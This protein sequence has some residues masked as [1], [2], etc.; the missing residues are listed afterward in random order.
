MNEDAGF[1][2]TIGF[3]FRDPVNRTS[4]VII[5]PDL[6]WGTFVSGDYSEGI[7]AM[8][9]TPNN[10]LYITGF[11]NSSDFPYV[12]PAGG[13]YFQDSL[14][15]FE[16]LFIMKFSDTGELL[17]STFYGG[18]SCDYPSQLLLD[19]QG[20]IFITGETNSFNF[21]TQNPG[22]NGFYQ[23]QHGGNFYDGFIL[24]FGSNGNRLWATY[25]GGENNDE[26]NGLAIDSQGNIYIAGYTQS[27]AFPLQNPANGAYFQPGTASIGIADVFLCKFSNDGQMLWSTYYGGSGSETAKAIVVDANDN[28]FVTGTSTSANFPMHYV[29]GAHYNPNIGGDYTGFLLK[30]NSNGVRLWGTG[31]GG[32]FNEDIFALALDDEN[33]LY[34][35]GLT[36]SPDFPLLNPGNGAFFQDDLAGHADAFISR[37]SNGGTLQWSTYF[38]GSYQEG[39]MSQHPYR[40]YDKLD[41]DNCGNVTLVFETESHDLPT[42]KVDEHSFFRKNP[43]GGTSDIYIARFCDSGRLLWGTYFGG[44]GFD[45]Q[46]SLEVDRSGNLYVSC[47]TGGS[48]VAASTYPLLDPGS[49]TFYSTNHSYMA[50]SLLTKF[51]TNTGS[52]YVDSVTPVSCT[53]PGNIDMHIRGLCYPL[54]FTWSNGEETL[55]TT[56]ESNSVGNLEEGTYTI[57]VTGE[58]GQLSETIEV[59]YFCP[60]VVPPV[61]E[62]LSFPNILT[63]NGDQLND[64]FVP[65]TASGITDYELIIVN[66]WG[67]EV[68]YTR[69]FE[70]GWNVQ[71]TTIS[72]TEGESDGNVTL[73]R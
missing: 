39:M 61:A 23:F 24:K 73:I 10:E 43:S 3:E 12:D 28:L 18:N 66:R 6:V 29:Q 8:T 46:P 27:Q 42:K 53:E 49:T 62:E 2:T 15:E 34:V 21:P 44:N 5:D 56:N 68:F 45:S 14:N 65:I 16:D 55:N 31:F 60:P 51:N 71:F 4:D 11:S 64:V 63:P 7:R 59:G 40:T 35:T 57:T 13:A 47:Y 58:C 1:E 33:R 37:F 32:M 19:A 69:S 20:D 30:F 48:T 36:D 52:L 9:S 70:D 38:G 54:S 50:A 22:N 72:G 41:V 17:W 67:Q 25:L 26:A